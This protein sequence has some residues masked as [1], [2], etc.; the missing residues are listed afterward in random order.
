MSLISFI[1]ASYGLTMI[2][3]YGKIF[4]SIRP[5][6]GFFGDMLKCTMCTGF[7]VGMVNWTAFT[8]PFNIFIAGFISAGTSYLLSKIVDDDGIAIKNK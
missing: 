1:L 7:W 5:K 6:E 8:L 2:A 3:A 4:N